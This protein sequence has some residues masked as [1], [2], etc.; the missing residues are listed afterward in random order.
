VLRRDA[1]R[2]AASALFFDVIFQD[3]EK[4]AIRGAPCGLRAENLR[5]CGD[6]WVIDAWTCLS[7]SSFKLEG[8]G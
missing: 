1:V 6:S 5:L 3:C 8:E 2:T 7:T 4:R